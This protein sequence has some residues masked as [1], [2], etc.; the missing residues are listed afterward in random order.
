MESK[1]AEALARALSRGARGRTPSPPPELLPFPPIVRRRV[2]IGGILKL[3]LA[4][5]I[6]LQLCYLLATS[7]LG[8]FA[9]AY[10]RVGSRR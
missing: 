4:W 2:T 3:V 1:Q 9:Q 7:I 5:A 10:G 8:L 6:A